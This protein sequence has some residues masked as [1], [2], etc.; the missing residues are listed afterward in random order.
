MQFNIERHTEFVSLTII[1]E[2]AENGSAAQYLPA[3]W[4]DKN[5]GE[6]V[7]AVD[8]Q[9]SLRGAA[10]DGWTCASRLE[11]GLADGFFDFKVAEDG[12]TKIALD[13][14]PDCDVR[15]VGRIALQVVEINLSVFCRHR[16][17]SGARRKRN[18]PM[19]PRVCQPAFQPPAAPIASVLICSAN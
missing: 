11:N 3:D 10:R 18:Y 15:D 17:Q 12:H 4:L 1:D 7:V 9:C 5:R 2:K 14:A 8:C 13:F 16:P 19:L 6:V